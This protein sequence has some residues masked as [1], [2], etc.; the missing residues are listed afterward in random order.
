MGRLVGAAAGICAPSS[1]SSPSEPSGR[2]GYAPGVAAI[3]VERCITGVD[4]TEPRLA[5]DAS[6]MVY[7][8]AAG[9]RAALMWQPLDGSPVRQLS[10]HPAPR[11]GRGM[12]GGC[13]C[14]SADG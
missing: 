12:G 9:G 5:P 6:C 8:A 13:W 7:A 3:P 1:P 14:W 10:S 2:H 11:T 4:L